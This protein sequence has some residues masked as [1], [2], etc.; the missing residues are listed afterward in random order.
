[1]I[2]KGIVLLGGINT[3]P[4][5]DCDISSHDEEYKVF[6]EMLQFIDNDNPVMIEAGSWWAFW[7]LVFRDKF[8]DGRNILIELGKRHIKIGIENFILNEFTEN[9][10][11]GGFYLNY[12]NTYSKKTD[13]YEF[14]K[15]E[16]EYFDESLSGNMTGPEINLEDVIQIEG[17]D[18]IDLLHLDIQGSE[19]PLLRYFDLDRI[20]NIVVATH[21]EE[22]HMEILSLLK[23]FK[24]I[25]N[26]A[27]GTMGGDGMITA[28]R[29]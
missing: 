27:F 16:G 3:R 8:P 15:I 14:E 23:D 29:K 24:I 28:T 6:T 10:Y 20:E 9:H 22:I 19:L 18:V 12:S 5:A 26:F 21:S 4:H 13:N 7:S 2:Y 11:W 1:M 25:S 17:I